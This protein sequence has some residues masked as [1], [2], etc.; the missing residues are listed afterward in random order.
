MK[1]IQRYFIFFNQLD[2]FLMTFSY[3]K[4]VIIIDGQSVEVVVVAAQLVSW[5]PSNVICLK[6]WNILGDLRKDIMI[7]RQV[8]HTHILISK[9]IGQKFCDE[10]M[11]KKTKNV[12]LFPQSW[13][14]KCSNLFLLIP[15]RAM[16]KNMSD[17][18]LKFKLL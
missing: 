4:W 7:L 17:R 10:N 15:F 9:Q 12:V 2:I 3:A 14:F 1:S 16:S 11:Q 5:C 13:S 18:W 6:R 8:L